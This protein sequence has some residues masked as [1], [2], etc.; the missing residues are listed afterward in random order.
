VAS[1]T[2]TSSGTYIVNATATGLKSASGGYL[3]CRVL[4]ASSS[5]GGLFSATPW[6][7]N[8]TDFTYGTMAVGGEMNVTA[9]AGSTIEERCQTNV[10]SGGGTAAVLDATL[11]GTLVNRVNGA[12]RAGGTR[13]PVQTFVK[14]VGPPTRGAKDRVGG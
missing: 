6:A 2:P 4:D 11:D 7:Y 3:A 9:R 13:R 12:V 5:R 1:T 14:P 8:N 10:I